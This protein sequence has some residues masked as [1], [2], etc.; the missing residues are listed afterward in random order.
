M[1]EDKTFDRMNSL[2]HDRTCEF[3]LTSKWAN[4]YCR[5]VGK[6]HVCHFSEQCNRECPIIVAYREGQSDNKW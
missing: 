6:S 4:G 1:I 5:I 3:W 2:E